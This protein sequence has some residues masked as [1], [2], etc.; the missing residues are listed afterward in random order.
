MFPFKADSIHGLGWKNL[1]QFG[2][3][4]ISSG[5]FVNLNIHFGIYARLFLLQTQ[6]KIVC[7]S[8]FNLFLGIL[9]EDTLYIITS[10]YFV[11]DPDMFLNSTPFAFWES[12]FIL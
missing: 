12:K 6:R 1:L 2:V 5:F 9:H 10:I 3:H 8:F 7:P 4:I 11:L